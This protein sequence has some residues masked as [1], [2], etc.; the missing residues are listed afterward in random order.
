MELLFRSV[1]VSHGCVLQA[2][3][4]RVQTSGLSARWW[5]LL[6]SC[7]YIDKPC[8]L[9]ML[10][11][12]RSADLMFSIEESYTPGKMFLSGYLNFF[13]P[14]IFLTQFEGLMTIINYEII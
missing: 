11:T 3:T 10:C 12:C 9:M 8:S 6:R 14:D 13:L 2:T 5:E 4:R 1:D 7:A